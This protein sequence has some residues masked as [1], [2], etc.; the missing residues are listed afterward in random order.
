MV[1]A[2]NVLF[3][4]GTPGDELAP[5]TGTE[6][7]R[8]GLLLALSTTDG[9]ELARCDLDSPPA[10]D[11]MAAAYGRLYV[12]TTDGKVLCLAGK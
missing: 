9:T 5:P 7:K 4:A 6:G 11:G 10:F 2:E 3:A 1:M 8:G 12:T